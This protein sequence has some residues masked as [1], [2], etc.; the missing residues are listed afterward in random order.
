VHQHRGL[1]PSESPPGRECSRRLTRGA[2]GF[3]Q[4]LGQGPD[5]VTTGTSRT[6]AVLSVTGCS[7]RSLLFSPCR[8]EKGDRVRPS[9]KRYGGAAC[10]RR[11][12]TTSACSGASAR[13]SCSDTTVVLH[14]PPAEEEQA[15]EAERSRPVLRVAGP[16]HLQRLQQKR[17]TAAGAQ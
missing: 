6:I 2:S 3:I 14:V 1:L 12:R 11:R 7:P 9:R 10:R 16:R 8:L 4:T 13:R 5:R 17:A 15:C